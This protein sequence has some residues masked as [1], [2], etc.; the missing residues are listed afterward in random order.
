MRTWR[1]PALACLVLLPG[2]AADRP[3]AALPALPPNSGEATAGVVTLPELLTDFPGQYT[4]FSQAARDSGNG[5]RP[6]GIVDLQIT[7]LHGFDHPVWLATRTPRYGTDKQHRLYR[8]MRRDDT[9]ELRADVVTEAQ[10]YAGLAELVRGLEAHFPVDCGMPLSLVD[11]QLSGHSNA[12]ACP[13]GTADENEL[14]L[15]RQV[16]IGPERF[17]IDEVKVWPDGLPAGAPDSLEFRRLARYVA[18]VR[19]RD[20]RTGEAWREATLDG[21]VDDG[22]LQALLTA[23]SEPL[24]FSLQLA[25]L[26]WKPDAEDYLRVAIFQSS[27]G[28]LNAYKWVERGGMRLDFAADWLEVTVEAIQPSE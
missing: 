24:G 19:V 7:R 2:C 10:L 6:P 26:P 28:T 16:H 22:R 5:R 20:P 27:S 1:L 23:E 11:G 12:N 3:T 9:L 14:G 21:A 17:T 4:N 13:S 25:W 15:F 18:T 8:L